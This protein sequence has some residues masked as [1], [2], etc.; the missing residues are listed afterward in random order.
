MVHIDRA[1][2]PVGGWSWQDSELSHFYPD[3]L[4]PL[5]SARARDAMASRTEPL[6]VPEWFALLAAREPALDQYEAFQVHDG[7]S[8]ITV[9]ADFR[10]EWNQHVH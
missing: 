1:L 9:V 7:I 6:S 4:D 8:L 3:K 5:V 2:G 10:R